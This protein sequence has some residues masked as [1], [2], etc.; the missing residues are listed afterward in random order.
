MS[1]AVNLSVTSSILSVEVGMVTVAV[2]VPAAKVK[3]CTP[4]V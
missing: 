3:V 2:V 1:R 4:P